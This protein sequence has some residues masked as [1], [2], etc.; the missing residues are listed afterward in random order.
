MIYDYLAKFYDALVQDDQATKKWVEFICKHMPKGDVLELACGSGEIS[1]ALASSGYKVIASDIS[2]S[3]LDVAR[4]KINA[5]LI[6]W[7]ELDMRSFDTQ[8]K[9]DGILCLCDS[10]NYVLS[11]DEI[12]GMFDSVYNALNEEGY[13]I[14]DMHSMDRLK[15]FKEEYVE[16]GKICEQNFQWSIYSEDDY[17]HQTFQVYDNQQRDHLEQ[18]IQRVY[19]PK[20]ILE[21]LQNIEFNVNIYTDFDKKDVCAG[22]K[23]FFVARKVK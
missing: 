17:I 2:L 12:K 4:K 20:V 6:K 3:M 19:E 10:I 1:L 14:F 18:H 16:T 8:R 11:L 21:Y 7:I 13:F 9:Y 5:E 23:I 22:E 15:E